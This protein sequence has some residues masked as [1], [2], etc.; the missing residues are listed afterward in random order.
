MD[1]E[2]CEILAVDIGG[3]STRTGIVRDKEIT[4]LREAKTETL[5]ELLSFVGD[6]VSL[7]TKGIAYSVGGVIEAHNRII[8]S[9]NLHFL[10]GIELARQTVTRFK[11]SAV[12]CNDMEASAVG[13]AKVFPELPYFMAITWS[14]GIGLR[15]VVDGKILAPSEGGHSRLDP[16]HC[17]PRCGCGLRG[18]AEAFLGG[19][20]LQT[21][22]IEATRA[23]GIIIPQGYKYP[24]IYLHTAYD[25]GQSW[26]Q[27]IYSSLTVH[28]AQF[29]TNIQHTMCLP[30]VVWKGALG[31]QVLRRAEKE[32]RQIMRG[33]MM[34]EWE[35]RMKFY[36]I[37]E[38]VS[39]KDG[40][41][42]IGAADV[43][44]QKMYSNG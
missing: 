34:V 38:R 30:A 3:S 41:A 15:F 32:I 40:E 35:E 39:L 37:W 14:S 21:T 6:G 17:A 7:G 24:S 29:L 42:L 33:L 9:P 2:Q 20:S 28:M 19:A 11:K 36:Y 4:D 18:C 25:E 23:A 1:S 5:V 31:E 44:L 27:N 22:V 13:M 10:D 16:S 12:V 43:L 8:V 26:A